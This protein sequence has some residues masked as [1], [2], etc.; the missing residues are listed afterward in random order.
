VQ[1]SLAVVVGRCRARYSTEGVRDIE[2][3]QCQADNRKIQM[4]RR[5]LKLEVWMLQ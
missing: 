4:K 2:A 3:A 1:N 5:R